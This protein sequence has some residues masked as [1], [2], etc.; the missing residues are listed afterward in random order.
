MIKERIRKEKAV[1]DHRGEKEGNA[2]KP[3]RFSVIGRRVQTSR[4]ELTTK[5]LRKVGKGKN[6]VVEP[7]K[8][9]GTLNRRE[10]IRVWGRGRQK[11]NAT[12]ATG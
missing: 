9:P 1:V 12:T 6:G 4:D 5:W 3:A 7:H 10:G 2:R 11:Y 8:T